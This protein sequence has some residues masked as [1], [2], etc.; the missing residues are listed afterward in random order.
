MI[1]RLDDQLGSILQILKDP[2]YGTMWDRT[3]T[4]AFT[5]HGEYLG[6]RGLVEKFPSGLDEVLSRDPLI[7]TGPD[8]QGGQVNSSLC[9]MVDLVPTVLELLGVAEAYPHSGLSLVPTMKG[10]RCPDVG[11]QKVARTI[12]NPMPLLKEDS[13]CGKSRRQRGLYFLTTKRQQSSTSSRM[14]SVEQ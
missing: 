1:S 6:D 9:E 14:S 11:S 3:Y 5:D 7:I 10:E 8:L 13:C 4:M 12:T 2:Q